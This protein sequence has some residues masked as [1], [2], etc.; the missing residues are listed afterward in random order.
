MRPSRP[1]TFALAL[2]LVVVLA[3]C[4]A[5]PVGDGPS[6]DTPE[7]DDGDGASDGDPGGGDASDGTDAGETTDAGDG[8][9]AGTDG[10]SPASDG[11]E[12]ATSDDPDSSESFSP[13]AHARALESAGSYTLEFTIVA[14][15]SDG[16]GTIVGTQQTD[17]NTGERYSSP[18]IDAGWRN[19]SFQ[20]YVPPNSNT[21]YRR[22]F[23]QTNSG[24]VNES[25][26]FMNY[27]TVGANETTGEWPDLTREGTGETALGPAT[28]YG[29]DSV[30]ALSESTREQ[31]DSVESVRIRAWVDDDTGAIAKYHYRLTVVT[32]GEEGSIRM[33]FELTDLGSTTIER[34]DWVPDD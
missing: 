2:V 20:A 31:Y 25:D 15:G 10:A 13:A 30:D 7:R 22:A 16:S 34:P 32:D 18:T 19:I 8:D 6:T 33:K 26:A 12:T 24:P 14:S 29:A 9:S 11:S 1:S 28:V 4:A 21:A 27:S 17:V 23:M 5:L 3:G